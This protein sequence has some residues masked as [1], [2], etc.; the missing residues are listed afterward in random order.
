M[1]YLLLLELLKAFIIFIKKIPKV[2]QCRKFFSNFFS[3][4]L[5]INFSRIQN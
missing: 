5:N 1:L 2:Q 3:S 4:A